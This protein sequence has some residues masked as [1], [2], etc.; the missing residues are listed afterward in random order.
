LTQFPS[1]LPSNL[2]HLN[3]PRNSIT[4]IS[5]TTLSSLTRLEG[6]NLSEN[7][8]TILPTQIGLLTS[9]QYLNLSMNQI[10]I[11]STQIGLLTSL[12]HSN[13]SHNKLSFIPSDLVSK[14]Q[15]KFS[16]EHNIFRF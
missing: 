8:I 16:F 13:L 11:L 5:L 3:L 2:V 7:Q 14:Q 4:S 12:Q 9:L 1:Q 10:T 15:Y 6:L